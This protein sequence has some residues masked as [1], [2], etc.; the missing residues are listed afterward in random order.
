M[1]SQMPVC[2]CLSLPL[3]LSLSLSLTRRSQGVFRC[4]RESRASAHCVPLKALRPVAE[5]TVAAV[6]LAT[7]VLKSFRHFCSG[8][9]PSLP[10]ALLIARSYPASLRR[11][12]SNPGPGR[13][14]SCREMP[15][16]PTPP[17]AF[18]CL[19]SL[20]RSACH[21]PCFFLSFS[22]R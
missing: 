4:K 18:P 10:A 12:T 14:M 21:S 2:R 13:A 1:T 11:S 6:Y 7:A 9:S 16:T 17:F 8:R 3:S 15:V 22:H 5:R 19:F 20:A